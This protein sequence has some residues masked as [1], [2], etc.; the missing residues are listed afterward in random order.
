MNKNNKNNIN[1]EFSCKKIGRILEQYTEYCI[2]VIEHEKYIKN[3]MKIRQQY[4]LRTHFLNFSVQLEFEALMI[5]F[6]Y[7]N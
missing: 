6:I 1:I 3:K 2:I 5:K 4:T 7:M